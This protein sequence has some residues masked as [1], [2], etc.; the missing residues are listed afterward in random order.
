MT[1][2]QSAAANEDRSPWELYSRV[3]RLRFLAI[4]F[5][6]GTANY[7]DR[8]IISVLLE[9][10]KHEFEVSDTMLGLLTGL[11]FAVFYATL[12]LPIARL[13]DN[14]NRKHV[15]TASLAVWSGMTMVCGLAGSYWQLLLARF[16]VGAGEAGAIPP[17]QSLLSDFFPPADRGKAFGIFMSSSSAGYALGLIAGGW[18]AQEYGWRHAFILAGAL[19]FILV[20]MTHFLL[21]EPR[22]AMAHFRASQSENSMRAVRALFA[23]PSYVLILCA[24]VAYFMWSYGVLVFVVSLLVRAHGLSLAEAGAMFGL[25]SAAGAVV[26]SVGGGAIADRLAR[27]DTGWLTRVGAIGIVAAVPV[28][29]V[30]LWTNN[31]ALMT[32]L[33][34]LSTVLLNGTVP[35]AY[36]AVHA[37]CGARRR[38]LAIALLLFFANLIGLGLGPLFSGML[39]DAFAVTLGN[40]EGLRLA[41]MIMTGVLVPAAM[42]LFFAARQLSRDLE[43]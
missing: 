39:S 35:P 33:L 25:V 19:S 31:M 3:Q 40:A 9:P 30:A 16:G 6:V 29:E 1:A 4:L 20:P 34:F 38:A 42:L 12:G 21:R 7:V 37:V 2:P 28:Y 24:L 26:G 32:G 41:L 22:R 15:V 14:W 27:H 13:A 36:A 5:L 23:K 11:S 8:N 18:I 17:A 43:D 10:I